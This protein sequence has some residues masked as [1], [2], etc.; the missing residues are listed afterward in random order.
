MAKAEVVVEV[1]V[2]VE[3]QV[4]AL[5]QVQVLVVANSQVNQVLQEFS[6]RFLRQRDL[7]QL[8]LGLPKSQLK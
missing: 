3:A 7:A 4:L 1:K 6:A 5:V 2:L 8:W